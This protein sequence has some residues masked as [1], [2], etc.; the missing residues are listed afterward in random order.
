[1]A[2]ATGDA[3]ATLVVRL[4]APGAG[5][6]GV[7]D[8]GRIV[9]LR[10]QRVADEARGGEFVPIHVLG[11]DLRR[12][13]PERGCLVADVYIPALL[14]GSTLR[15]FAYDAPWH[16]VGS[17]R[18]YLAANLAW[19]DDRGLGSWVGEGA[20]A[21]T[22][23]TLGRTILGAGATAVGAGPLSRCVVWPG[24]TATAP[25]A[26]VVIAGERVVR[27]DGKGLSGGP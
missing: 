3:E 17:L 22:A 20:H 5:N 2:H 27:A 21:K 15:A 1:L 11:A 7:D 4:L 16:D 25:L 12:R 24:S 6:V 8:A 18:T 13:L 19:L 23:V 10:R 26:D 14:G 9:R